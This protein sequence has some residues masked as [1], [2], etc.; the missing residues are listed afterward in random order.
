MWF[1]KGMYRLLLAALLLGAAGCSTAVEGPFQKAGRAYVL[2]NCRPCPDLTGGQFTV[3]VRVVYEGGNYVIPFHMDYEGNVV[4]GVEPF[5]LT[6]GGE[7][8]PAGTVV[9]FRL[10]MGIWAGT[11]IVLVSVEV[12]GDMTVEV[13]EKDWNDKRGGPTYRIIPGRYTG[14]P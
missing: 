12:D 14:K 4:P 9:E 10:E 8:F 13:Y 6:L 1:R 7:L 11:D 2:N 3:F 5:D